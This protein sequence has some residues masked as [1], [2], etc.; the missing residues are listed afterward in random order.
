MSAGVATRIAEVTL[1]PYEVIH[2][3]GAPAY[4]LRIE[5]ADKVVTC[6]GDTEWTD[7][8]ISAAD[9]A[10]LFICECYTIG[11]K[12]SYHMDYDGLLDQTRRLTVR[13]TLVTHMGPDVLTST[14]NS[15]EMAED[16]LVIEV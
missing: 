7:A 14:R 4:A 10:D 3:S 8:P 13:R 5:A 2:P 9:G 12:V 15:L 16:G 1:I 11:R 6:S